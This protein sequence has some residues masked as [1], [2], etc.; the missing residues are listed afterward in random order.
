MEDWI[1]TKM[2]SLQTD[3]VSYDTTSCKLFTNSPRLVLDT[4]DYS[5]ASDTEREVFV[6]GA[7]D[8]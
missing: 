3:I 1:K 8:G 6:A 7:N 5:A 2:V 4:T